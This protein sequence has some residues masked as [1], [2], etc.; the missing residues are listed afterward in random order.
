MRLI[1]VNITPALRY[2]RKVK[3]NNPFSTGASHPARGYNT[4]HPRSR[5]STFSGIPGKDGRHP[6]NHLRKAVS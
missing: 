2:W 5:V 4:I 6:L 1:S 3:K